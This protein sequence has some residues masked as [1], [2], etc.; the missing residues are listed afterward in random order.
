M[1]STWTYSLFYNKTIGVYDK[2]LFEKANDFAYLMPIP[3]DYLTE[4]NELN[5]IKLL[6]KIDDCTIY[7]INIKSTDMKEIIKSLM[8]QV[9][10][11]YKFLT[12]DI[13]QYYYKQIDDQKDHLF[14]NTVCMFKY[15]T[16]L[17]VE[18]DRKSN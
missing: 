11:R 5:M 17:S 14:N 18:F 9:N 15:N 16:L 4:V 2:C 1:L 6:P 8:F 7:I 10:T 12:D 3:F 13:M